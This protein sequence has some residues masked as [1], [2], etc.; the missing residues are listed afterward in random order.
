MTKVSVDTASLTTVNNNSLRVTL[1][2]HLYVSNTNKH[3]L[4]VHYY[5]FKVIIVTLLSLHLLLLYHANIH[6][7]KRRLSGIH[8][9]HFV[10]LLV[11]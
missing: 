3:T 9:E 8:Y 4:I 7:D 10:C 2:T 1:N 5:S 11:A 6:Y